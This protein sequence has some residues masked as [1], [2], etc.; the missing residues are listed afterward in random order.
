MDCCGGIN[1]EHVVN[2]SP[3]ISMV[4]LTQDKEKPCFVSSAIL[5]FGYSP[6]DFISGKVN[7]FDLIHTDDASSLSLTPDCTPKIY[8]IAASDGSWRWVAHKICSLESTSEVPDEYLWTISDITSFKETDNLLQ[9][10][11][12]E[13]SAFLQAIPAVLLVINEDGKCL[14]ITGSDDPPLAAEFSKMVGKR[15]DEVFPAEKARELLASLK[16]SIETEM[17]QFFTYEITLGGKTYFQEVRVSPI[18]MTFDGKRAAMAVALDI[19]ARKELDDEIMLQTGHDPLGSPSN[20]GHFNR[21]FLLSL[22]EAQHTSSSLAF[23]MIDM[24]HFNVVNEAIGRDMADLLLK[25]VAHR[26]QNACRQDDILYRMEGVNFYLILPKLRNKKEAAMVAE[27]LLE[28]VKTAARGYNGAV[29]L[30]ATIGISLFPLNGGDASELLRA[31]ETALSI[32][33]AKGGNTY[34]FAEVEDS[35]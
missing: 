7:Y 18:P 20:R 8:R 22:A 2:I 27:R 34:S 16:R 19:T 13:M 6:E 31:A 21:K 30:T 9:K 10:K 12:E 5:S 29:S 32:G 25:S 3:V 35:A 1:F 24:D 15:V 17:S 11:E 4:W 28:I 14:K 26:L 23:F 33:K